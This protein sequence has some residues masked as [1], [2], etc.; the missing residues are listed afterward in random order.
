MVD[1]CLYKNIWI[2]CKSKTLKIFEFFIIIFCK[3]AGNCLCEI[4]RVFPEVCK[5]SIPKL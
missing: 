3:W 5:K 2:F 4:F 1:I